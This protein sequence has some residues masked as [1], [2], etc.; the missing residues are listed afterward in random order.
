MAD[1]R[2][3]AEELAAAAG[4]T[5]SRVA[6]ISEFSSPMPMPVEFGR[7]RIEATAIADAAG[8]DVPISVG[9][10]EISIDLQVTYE[11]V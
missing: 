6:S 9:M 5:I 8:P 7:D 10:N 4:M 3:K 1:A 2:T 11:L